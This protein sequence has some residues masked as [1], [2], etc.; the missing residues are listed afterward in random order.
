MRARAVMIVLERAKV[1]RE[2]KLASS[3]QHPLAHRNGAA[4]PLAH[5]SV[6]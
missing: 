4:Q 3:Y 6:R 5:R 2:H 1:V